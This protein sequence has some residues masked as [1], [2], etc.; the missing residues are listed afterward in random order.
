MR[1][2]KLGSLAELKALEYRYE[3]TIYLVPKVVPPNA[4]GGAPAKNEYSEYVWMSNESDPLPPSEDRPGFVHEISARKVLNPF[5]VKG[6]VPGVKPIPVDA[7]KGHWE[8]L[9]ETE[10]ADL[11]RIEEELNTEIERAIARENELETAI[12]DETA[13]AKVAESELDEKI[14]K[15]EQRATEREN[16][17]ASFIESEAERARKA[18]EE[19]GEKIAKE[20]ARAEDKEE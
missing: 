5:S 16:E 9:G 19:L 13:R 3:N 8:L 17:L 1:H 7:T 20:Q 10:E 4:N 6:V 15:E 11:K 14:E 2:I 12:N 18:E